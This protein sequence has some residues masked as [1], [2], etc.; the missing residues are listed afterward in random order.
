MK[1]ETRVYE[2]ASQ[3]SIVVEFANQMHVPLDGGAC[4]SYY[5]GDREQFCECEHE[6]GK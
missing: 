3:S 2:M 4:G 1:R 5:S 6:F